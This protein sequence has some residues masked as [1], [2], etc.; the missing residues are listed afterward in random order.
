MVFLEQNIKGI[1]KKFGVDFNGLLEDFQVD[2]V[3]EL[4]ISDL[5]ALTEE[6]E[7]DLQALLF[8]PLFKV[9]HLEEKLSKIKLLIL[10]VD[11]VLSDGG[12]YFA[13]SGDQF[14]KFNTKDGRGIIELVK[15][16][17]QVGIISSGFRDVGV[18]A[19]A[20]MLGIQHCYIGL[21]PKIDILTQW[22]EELK[23]SFDE[24]A[25][26][27]DDVN[28]LEVMQRI[29]FKTCPSDAVEVVKKAVDLILSKPG[30]QG[31]VREF[32]DNYLEIVPLGS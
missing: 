17:M 19:R 28:D 12:M 14:K 6:Y 13:E 2:S 25:M 21:E 1:C 29:G 27:G 18:T 5:E 11:G 7:I 24:V 26:I 10:D 4:A 31:C 15:R 30:G 9:P 22:C 20:K 23:I 16:G 3:F 8:K 32:I